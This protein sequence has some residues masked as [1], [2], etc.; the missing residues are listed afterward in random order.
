MGYVPGTAEHERKRDFQ[1]EMGTGLTDPTNDVRDILGSTGRGG[2]GNMHSGAKYDT[3][4]T[5]RHT[6]NVPSTGAVEGTALGHG[7][8]TGNRVS[9]SDKAIGTAE[10]TLGK[11]MNKP[12][13]VEKGVER[14]VGPD[15]LL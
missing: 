3:Q 10:E 14:Q 6:G 4:G 15:H 9:V 1:S 2:V 7:T 5:G 8:R 13:M 11:V 12:G